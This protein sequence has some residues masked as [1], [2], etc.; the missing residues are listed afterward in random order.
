MMEPSFEK[1]LAHLAEAQIDFILVGGLAVA[2]NGFVRLT[3]DVDILISTEPENITRFLSAMSNFGEGHGAT[4]LPEDFDD[5]PGA[6]RLIEE[7]EQSQ[8]DIF[9]QMDG[10]TY[11]DWIPHTNSLS[12]NGREIRYASRS[13]LIQFKSSSVREKD[14]IDVI[15]LRKLEEEEATPPES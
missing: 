14:Q 9:T 11:A 10:K 3:E 15:A 12:L 5:S 1:L 8:L 4:F 13:M 6:L 2:L 7:S